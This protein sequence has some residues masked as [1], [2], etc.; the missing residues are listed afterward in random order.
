M[1]EYSVDLFRDFRVFRGHLLFLA[2][3]LPYCLHPPQHI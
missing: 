3:F 1:L 2:S